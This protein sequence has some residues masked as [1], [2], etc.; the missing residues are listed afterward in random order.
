[1]RRPADGTARGARPLSR[2]L[3]VALA[4]CALA[5][6]ASVAWWIVSAALGLGLVTFATGSMSPDYP[7]G[8]LAVSAP[9]A[10]RDVRA[11]DVV[12]VQRGSG[13]PPITHRVVAV[14]VDPSGRTATVRLKGDAN[15]VQDPQPYTVTA[16]RR[17]VQPLPAAADVL[18]YTGSPVVIAA[19]AAVI[20]GSLGWAFWPERIRARHRGPVTTA[21]VG[22][23]MGRHL[24]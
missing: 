9:I 14:A 6:L 22:P 13:Q 17:V 12:T 7:T 23:P 8:S 24:A 5:G 15:R 20:A 2:A 18:R 11:G 21:P 1:M 16:L 10:L 4:C 19:V 3:D